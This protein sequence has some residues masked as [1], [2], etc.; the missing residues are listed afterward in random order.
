[1]FGNGRT[2]I[3]GTAGRYVQSQGTG[4]AA[5]YNPVVIS[6]DTRTW[7]DTNRD[8]IAQESELGPTSNVNFGTRQNQSHAPNIS[9]PYQWVYDIAFQH[10]VLR[11]VGVSVS[12]NRRNFYNLI[13]TQ[14]LA[15]PFSAYS[16]T[17]VANPLVADETIPIYNLAPAAQGQVNLLD[18]NS[19]NNRQYYQGVD[20]TVNVRWRGATLN[21]GTST[22]RTLSI[23]CD[24]QDPNSTRYCDQTTYDVPFRTLFRLSGTYGLPFGVR[25]SAVVQSIPGSAR[26]IT[27]VVTRAI[28]PTLTQASVTVPLNHP[29]TQFLDTVNQLDLSFSKTVR[30]RSVEI[31]PE[32][33]IFNALNAAPVT[34]QTNAFGPN[35]DRVTAILPGRL[36]RVGMTVRY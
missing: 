31:R 18:D 5:T 36:V 7:N 25:A 11:G 10:E 6:T 29:N 3:K 8:D 1:V 14:N 22:G 2:A 12:Y 17:S 28:V 21:G 30:A 15:A 26:T 24:V 4:F 20:V 16:L 35:L 32:V 19:P 34:A 33:G 9:R 23:L 13:W 27:Y